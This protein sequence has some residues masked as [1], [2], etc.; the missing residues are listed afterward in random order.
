MLR[1]PSITVVIVTL[2]AVRM[3]GGEIAEH[4]RNS[5]DN[6]VDRSGHVACNDHNKSAT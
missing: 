6:Q 1:M 2:V 3:L 5:L 4:V